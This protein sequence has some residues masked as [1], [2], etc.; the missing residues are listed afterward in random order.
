MIHPCCI[1]GMVIEPTISSGLMP[2]L[3]PPV[4][5]G[6]EMISPGLSSDFVLK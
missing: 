2:Q 6:S 4:K 3:Y 1:S 5:A